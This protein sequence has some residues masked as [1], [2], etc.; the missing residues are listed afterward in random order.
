MLL[1]SG[2]ASIV[3]PSRYLVRVNS[4][5]RG[6]EVV[7]TDHRG[8]E[9]YRGKSLAQVNL[10][11]AGGFFRAARYQVQISATGYQPQ[12]VPVLFKLN[13]WYFGNIVFGGIIGMLIVDPA[14]GAMWRIADPIVDVQL[15]RGPRVM[16]SLRIVTPDMLTSAQ[17]ARMV[18]IK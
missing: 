13:N 1:C 5:P 12:T 6:A 15:E 9:V 17:K 3:S 7:I 18:R 14:T 11:S 16:G 2:C 10:K 4:E 8:T